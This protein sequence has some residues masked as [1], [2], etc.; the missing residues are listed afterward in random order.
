MTTKPWYSQDPEVVFPIGDGAVFIGSWNKMVVLST[1]H[2]SQRELDCRII[3]SWVTL[4]NMIDE[5]DIVATAVD[6]QLL[7]ETKPV[8]EI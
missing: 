2:A 6:K 7:G 8:I 3:T 4:R 1:G 5:M